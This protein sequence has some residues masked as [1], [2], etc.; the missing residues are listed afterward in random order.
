MGGA[1]QLSTPVYER[2]NDCEHFLVV[3][4]V[5][6]FCGLYGLGVESDR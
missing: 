6:E 4:L 5:V 2:F 3:H 1:G